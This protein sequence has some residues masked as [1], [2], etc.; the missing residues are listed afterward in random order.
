[1][2]KTVCIILSLCILVCMLTGCGDA[3]KQGEQ[4]EPIRQ[5]TDSVGR[6]VAVP[7]EISKIAISGPLSQVY[8]LPLAGDMLV[9]VSRAFSQDA[10]IYLP[11]YIM[12][13]PEIGQLYG[14]KGEMNLEALLD[15]APDVVIDIGDAN[16]SVAEDMDAL[17]E[18][19]GIPFVHIDATTETSA[20][21]Y[22]V[23]GDLL[24]RQEKAEKLASW[25][26]DTLAMINSVMEKVDAD[27]NRKSI[28]YCLGDTGTNVMAEG[29]FHADTINKM[30]K[31]M[32]SIEEVSFSGDG[33]ESDVEQI[34]TWNP[35]VIIFS[36]ESIFDTVGESAQWKNVKAITDGH[37]YEAPYGPYGWLSSPPAVQR[38]LGMLWLGAVLYPDYVEFDLQEKTTEYFELFYGCELTDAMYR[39]LVGSSK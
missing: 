18:Q 9:G 28:L 3:G 26:E 32:A 2:K 25:C 7:A 31:N 8:I 15:A 34:M 35:D 19:T 23:L 36:P 11:S 37:Y 10:E 13:L 30:G 22:R 6:T 39:D 38:Y 16:P 4:N 27:G 29:S 24:G 14:G 1:M 5:F 12:E 17:T 33:N 20:E 21:A